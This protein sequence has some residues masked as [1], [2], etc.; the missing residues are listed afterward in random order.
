MEEK[1]K[2]VQFATNLSFPSEG[3]PMTYYEDF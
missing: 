1:Q 3:K 2:L